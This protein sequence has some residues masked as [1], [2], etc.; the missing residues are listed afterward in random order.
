MTPKNLCA[1]LLMIFCAVFTNA[2]SFD[3]NPKISFLGFHLSPTNTRSK[4]YGQS[5]IIAPANLFLNENFSIHAQYFASY[6]YF[7]KEKET[8]NKLNRANLNFNSEN[9]TFRAGRDFLDLGLNSVIYFGAYEDKDLRKPSYFDGAFASYTL[10]DIFKLSLVGGNYKKKDFYGSA[11]QISILK[12]FY[13]SSKENNLDLS[14]YG[15]S[16]NFESENFDLDFLA[17][18]NQ[19]KE[20]RKFLGILLEKKY[21]GKIFSGNMKLKSQGE[22]F[23]MGVS[24]GVEYLS[25]DKEDY[26]G[27]R[28][29]YANFDKGFIFGNLNEG[30]ETLTYKLGFAIAPKAIKNLSANMKIYNFASTDKNKADK[31]IANEI[32]LSLL[33]QFGNFGAK[34]IYGYLNGGASFSNFVSGMEDKSSINTTGFILFCQF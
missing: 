3:F 22:N 7:D 1:A 4:N 10:A 21:R 8:Y 29:I 15:A 2:T 33:Y 9:F 34:I 16:L 5:E 14:V 20:S 28:P 6:E 13:L 32:D 26:L 23:D 25:P 30:L 31:S 11:L 12:G 27:Y 24:L 19:G 17:A 18:F